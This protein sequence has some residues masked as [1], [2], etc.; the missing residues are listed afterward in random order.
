MFVGRVVIQ[1]AR[2][3]AHS[4]S[5]HV[6]LKRM[7]RPCR[8]RSLQRDATDRARQLYPILHAISEPQQCA[9]VFEIESAFG[10]LAPRAPREQNLRELTPCIWIG[11]L[12][13]SHARI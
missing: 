7:P 1:P 6:G 11:E 12:H 10:E 3:T 5:R 13:P 2:Q 9:Q 4:E 8:G